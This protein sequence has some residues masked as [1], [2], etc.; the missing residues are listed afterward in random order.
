[1]FFMYIAAIV[2]SALV[3]LLIRVFTKH[4][5]EEDKKVLSYIKKFILCIMSIA[6]IYLIMDYVLLYSGA[7]FTVP[8][9]R[10]IDMWAFI[11]TTYF[12]SGYVIHRSNLDA[13]IKAQYNKRIT[14][15]VIPCLIMAVIIYG[16]MMKG[17]Y[18]APE[19]VIRIS[20]TVME[21]IIDV[22]MLAIGLW[23]IVITVPRI[24]DFNIR[25]HIIL[26]F[27]FLFAN[28]VWNSILTFFLIIDRLEFIKS[29]VYDFTAAYL[30]LINLCA[31]AL[32]YKEDYEVGSIGDLVAA[33]ESVEKMLEGAAE[34][35][36][37]TEREYQVM[38][39]AYNGYTNPEIAEELF[40]S[41]NTVKIHMHNIF[42][43]LGIST[44]TELIHFIN[45]LK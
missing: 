35:Y 5:N 39:L 34:K 22:I 2:T 19:G 33:E 6:V 4:C 32:I 17:Y 15:S 27:V 37:L 36:S 1:M 18:I 45:S 13:G 9:L 10:I 3:I 8:L 31:M 43:K 14:L 26:I 41:R 42:V 12:F 16:F 40:I 38:V 11:G 28:N 25:K 7:H 30:L 44:R 24:S 21:I 23:S 20:A 29:V